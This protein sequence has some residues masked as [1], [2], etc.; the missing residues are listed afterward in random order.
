MCA[1]GAGTLGLRQINAEFGGQLRADG[2][3]G[4]R[5]PAPAAAWVTGG[6]A[7]TAA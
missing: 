6:G 5:S 1:T 7:R 4:T 2:E 3:A